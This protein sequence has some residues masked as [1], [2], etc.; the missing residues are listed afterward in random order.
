MTESVMD[1]V[2]KID[3]EYQCDIE[4]KLPSVMCDL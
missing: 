1:I 2:Q 3:G 4:N